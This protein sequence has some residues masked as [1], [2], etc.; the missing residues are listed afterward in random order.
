MGWLTDYL[1]SSYWNNIADAVWLTKGVAKHLQNEILS[2][3]YSHMSHFVL[4]TCTSIKHISV[5]SN[6]L[7]SHMCRSFLPSDCKINKSTFSWFLPNL[8]SLLDNTRPTCTSLINW[9]I[10]CYFQISSQQ[11]SQGISWQNEFIQLCRLAALAKSLWSKN[12][13]LSGTKFVKYSFIQ[14][15]T[16]CCY[17]QIL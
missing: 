15:K 2:H 1:T 5:V 10:I 14:N 11:L 16:F 6:Y 3:S 12:Y 4:L 8:H 9:L 17:W 13:N 7:L